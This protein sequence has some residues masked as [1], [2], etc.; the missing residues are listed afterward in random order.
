MWGGAFFLLGVFAFNWFQTDN[1][2]IMQFLGASS[3]A[4]YAAIQRLFSIGMVAQFFVTP[5]WPAYG[6]AIARGDYTW[7]RRTLNRALACSLALTGAVTLPFLAFG[8]HIV[9]AWLHTQ[10]APSFLLLLGFT[11][12]NMLM[13]VAGNLSTL[14]VHGTYLRRQVWFYG[15]ASCAAL[16]LKVVFVRQAGVPGVVWASVLGF[17]FLY[18]PFALRLAYQSVRGPHPADSPIPRPLRGWR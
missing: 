18:T 12:V 1:L 6:E 9:A 8:Q 14:L 2:I 15:L 4:E 11:L 10:R 7:A 5:L 13:I 17:G 16:M 3:V